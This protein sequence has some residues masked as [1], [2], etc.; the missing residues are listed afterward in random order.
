VF[1]ERTPSSTL[2]TS[3]ERYDP[4][5]A[6]QRGA[7]VVVITGKI[8][9]IAAACVLVSAGV[10][11]AVSTSGQFGGPTSQKVGGSALRIDLTIADGAVADV[12]VAA[13]A[14][15]GGSACSFNANE[16][17]SFEFDKGSVRLNGQGNFQGTLKDANGQSVSID[18][19][20]T[21]TAATGSFEIKAFGLGQSTP[22][23]SSG[24]VTFDAVAAGQQVK[25]AQYSGSVGPGYPISFRVSAS[26]STVDDLSVAIEATCQP[27]AADVAPKYNLKTLAI[28]SGTFSGSAF[29]GDSDTSNSIRVTGT[30][31]GRTVVGEV[32]DLAHI[33]S[34]PDC[35]QAEP[36]TATAP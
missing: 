14:D 2:G 31:F 4:H 11:S 32:T 10:A 15:H 13:F 28:S 7:Q 34:L 6:R 21:A 36:F 35:T 33:K 27:G 20:V 29:G 12:G 3:S 24:K 25:N 9:A 5:E 17:T 8:L 16:G 18:G 23:C 1:D 22:T 19:R 30:F 26:G